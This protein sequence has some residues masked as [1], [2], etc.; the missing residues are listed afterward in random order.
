[1]WQQFFKD[2]FTFT[3]KERT[4]ILL[5]LVA[6]ALLW[7][8]PEFIEPATYE[9]TAPEI[10]EFKAAA[11][12]LHRTT[13]K[14]DSG[15]VFE[16]KTLKKSFPDSGNTLDY[17]G[18]VLFEFDPNTL[19]LAGWRKLGLREKTIRTI[20]NFLAKGGHF[21]KPEDIGKI[22][23]L[24]KSEYETLLPY[25]SIREDK[26]QASAKLHEAGSGR[27]GFLNPVT[28]KSA[29]L[30]NINTADSAGFEALPGIGGKLASRIINFR[31]RLG[32]FHNVAQ[33]AETYG[34]HDSVFQ[35]IR[36]RLIISP[37]FIPTIININLADVKTLQAHPYI[38]FTIANAIVQYRLQHGLFTDINDLQKID[39]ITPDL[40]VRIRPYL[41][42]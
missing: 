2:Y 30:V 17:P 28:N 42:I 1:M 15:L 5:L 18:G 16:E 8:I 31:N 41:T 32:G 4:G 37:E 29:I 3:R 11:A 34:L 38:R 25:V 22:F 39:L 9:L 12:K 13:Q 23:G 7:L 14:E 27:T 19:S 36:H 24:T 10:E 35:R 40:L 26:I 20:Q 33:V 21:Y 6:I